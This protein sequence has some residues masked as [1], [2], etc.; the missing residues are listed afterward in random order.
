VRFHPA[1]SHDLR[2]IA[3]S[4][5]PH[6]GTVTSN[7]II[8]ELRNAA[9]SLQETPHRGTLRHEVMPNLRA[10]P[11]ARRGVVVFTVDEV[12]REVFVHIIAYGG[13]DWLSRLADR[14][15]D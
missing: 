14:S 5:L 15:R 9:R 13:A 1:I 12:A 2:G 7:R 6:A 10:I 3:R 11:A 4:M 8:T